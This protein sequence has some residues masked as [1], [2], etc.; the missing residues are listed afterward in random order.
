MKAYDQD[1]IQQALHALNEQVEEAWVVDEGMLAKTF[2]F[3]SFG[4]AFSFMTAL[5]LYAEKVDHHPDWRNCFRR[6]DIRL[7]TFDVHG[8]TSQDFDFAL[9][10]EKFAMP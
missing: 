2:S 1:Q 8:L 7:S 4:H 5:A 3:P 9:R 6:V 10:A